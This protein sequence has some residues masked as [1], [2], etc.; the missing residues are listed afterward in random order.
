[1]KKLVIHDS[2]DSKRGDF[3]Q[4]L[5]AIQYAFSFVELFSFKT[6]T[7]EHQGDVSFDDL[8]QIETKH[9]KSPHAL[10]D[11]SEEFWKT[12]YNWFNQDLQFQKLILHTTSHFPLKGKSLLKSWNKSN[13]I[14]R[15]S[16]LKNVKFDFH[17]SDIKTFAI[18]DR[19]IDILINKG[20][21]EIT[22]TTLKA[23]KFKK[24][25]TESELSK[26]CLQSNISQKEIDIIVDV[27]KDTTD[28]KFKVWNYYRVINSYPK[29]KIES[30][31]AKVVINAKQNN[32]TETITQISELPNFI[33]I[34]KS[35]SDYEYLI[36]AQIAGKI[37]SK[38]VG[39]KKWAVSKEE[40][41]NII[42][43][44]KSDFYKE[45]YRPIFDKYLSE[46]PE[47]SVYEENSKKRFVEELER[48]KCDNDDLKDAIVDYWKTNSLIA[49]ELLNNP[50]FVENEYN[51][52]K[53]N[54]VFPV[55]KNQKK[56]VLKSDDD[57]KNLQSSLLLYRQ[58][59]NYAF[60]DFNKVKS[61]TYFSHGTIHNIVEDESKNFNWLIDD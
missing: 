21:E 3:Y 23:F 2:S 53:D 6:L 40:F 22:I 19:N 45:N 36:S 30:I 37:A 58:T 15:I 4:P 25:K 29:E 39:D 1:M 35:T 57:N 26:L 43:N 20:V 34:C 31:V 9:H 55:I 5:V 56:M 24:F 11:T 51:P 50:F 8:V 61:Y 41:Y 28:T 12:L 54:I 17:L 38:V 49:E 7:I 18:S 48:I 60:R 33:G 14:D 16:I 59:K 27:C 42:N 32:D 44:A 47:L 46:E 52:Y 13:N 10:G